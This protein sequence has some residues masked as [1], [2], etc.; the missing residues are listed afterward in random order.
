MGLGVGVGRVS[1]SVFMSVCESVCVSTCVLG[2]VSESMGLC[3]VT[4]SIAFC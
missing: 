3:V 1:M 2:G 4:E